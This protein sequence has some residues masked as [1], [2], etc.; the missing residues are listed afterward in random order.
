MGSYYSGVMNS[1]YDSELKHWGILGQKWGIRRF[2]N[3]DGTLTPAGKERYYGE[4][5]NKEL[6]KMMELHPNKFEDINSSLKAFPQVK[7]TVKKLED[8][9]LNVID[10]LSEVLKDHR[11]VTNRVYSDKECYNKYLNIAID[12]YINNGPNDYK[13]DKNA[14]KWYIENDTDSQGPHSIQ[15]MYINMSNEQLARNAR[16]DH[17]RYKSEK[18]SLD[19]K[20][21]EEAKKLLGNDASNE[22]IDLL[23]ERLVTLAI[24]EAWK[25]A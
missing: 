17:E 10:E 2:Q 14:T 22:S 12:E 24:H 15:S 5:G 3:E 19:N 16:I 21:R 13:G 7:Y 25:N 6:R 9:A 20:A 23:T 8:P 18:S 11:K 4:R 1:D